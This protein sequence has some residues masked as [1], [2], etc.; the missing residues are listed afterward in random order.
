[1]ITQRSAALS[2]DVLTQA[3][4]LLAMRTTGPTDIRAI[5]AWVS[6]HGDAGAEVVASLPGLRTGEAWV[7]NPER[8]LLVRT[9]IRL[10]RTFDSSSTP[11]FGEARA[12]PEQLAAVAPVAAPE[13]PAREAPATTTT[14]PPATSGSRIDYRQPD[15]DGRFGCKFDGC[16]GRSRNK[17][18]RYAY[19]CAD[20][21]AP[22]AYASTFGRGSEPEPEPAVSR[23]DVD[24][25]DVAAPDARSNGNG[26]H[27]A[28]SAADL[29]QTPLRASLAREVVYLD[30]IATL[31]QEIEWLRGVVEHAIG[32]T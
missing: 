17:R 32:K 5:K 8:D 3:D 2:K 21:H 27:V 13:P 9:Q 22:A 6:H 28:A 4:V 26:P 29:E 18:G 16:P 23:H 10:A 7:W 30:R 14:T 15:A 1:M 25:T 11:R 20:V 12:E 31:E 19:L 24:T